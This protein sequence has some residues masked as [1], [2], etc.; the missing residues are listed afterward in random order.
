MKEILFI[1]SA[2]PQGHHE[3]S[4]YLLRYLIDALG[5]DYKIVH[6]KMPEPDNPHYDGW[7]KKLEAELSLLDGNVVIGHSLGGS[8]VL[9]YLSELNREV[10]LAGLFV[11][12][13]PFWGAPEWEVDEYVLPRNLS[14]KLPTGTQLFLYHSKDDEV[15]PVEHVTL[16]AVELPKAIVR[17]CNSRGHLFSKGLPELV[18]DIKTV[19]HG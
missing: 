14:S 4:D 11:I 7:K 17:T 18:D 3:G 12:A 10:P 6:P 2:G 16:Y 5:P 1:H 9:K 8:V 19:S 13:A 15:V